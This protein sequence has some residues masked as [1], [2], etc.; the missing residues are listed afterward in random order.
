MDTPMEIRRDKWLTEHEG[1]CGTC[2]YHKWHRTAHRNYCDNEDSYEC[3]EWKAHN[4]GCDKYV[5][6]RRYAK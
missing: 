2:R 1:C 3:G 6:K 4:E 5:A